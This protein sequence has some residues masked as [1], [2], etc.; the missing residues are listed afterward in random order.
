MPRVKRGVTVNHRHKRLLQMTKGHRGGRSRLIKQAKESLLHALSHAY[1]HRRERKGD[2][3]RLWIMRINAAA[4][5][6]GLS[7]SQ[8][9]HGLDQA[10]VLVDRKMLADIAV[11]DSQAFAQV[12]STAKKGLP[13][14]TTPL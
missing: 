1:R 3:R 8:F 2:M 9:I 13:A 14:A 10:Q 6:H 5:E 4:R 11:K 12:V 7:Y